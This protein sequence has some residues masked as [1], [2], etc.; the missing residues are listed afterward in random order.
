MPNNNLISRWTFAD[1]P[2]PV[3]DLKAEARDAGFGW[4][5]VEAAKADLAIVAERANEPG[6]GRGAGHWHWCLPAG[7]AF[8]TAGTKSAEFAVLN[9]RRKTAEN[10]ASEGVRTFKAARPQAFTDFA[11]LNSGEPWQEGEV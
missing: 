8:K 1:G 2:M 3:N 4:R 7:R 10:L 9:E 6:A 5:T 11:D